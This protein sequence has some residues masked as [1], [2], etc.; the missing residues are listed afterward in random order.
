MLHRNLTDGRNHTIDLIKLVAALFVICI[1]TKTTSA[2]DHFER[3][4]FSF[5][6]DNV[7]RFAVPFFFAAS[8]FLI[9]FSNSKKVLTRLISIVVVCT[10][11]SFIFI[12][13]RSSN[14]L[15]YP[16]FSFSNNPETNSHLNTIYKILFYGYERHLWF[17][18][19]YVIAVGI[20][21]SLKRNHVTLIFLAIIFY[22]LGISGQQF[23]FIYPEHTNLLLEPTQDWLQK[24]YFTRSGMFFAFPCMAIGYITRQYIQRFR[25]IPTYIVSL[26]VVALFTLQYFECMAVMTKFNASTADYYISTLPLTISILI[27]SIKL[28]IEKPWIK[29]AGKLAGGVYVIHPLFMY[30]FFILHK[31]LFEHPA[32]PY[33]FTPMLFILSI[34]SSVIISKIP[35]LRKMIMA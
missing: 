5:I 12:Y 4:S 31:D 29:N 19:A 14:N 16:A 2:I 28:H 7:A 34:I 15:E 17:F 30:Y 24:T 11:W 3:G 22:I 33:I 26:A 32:W 10:V 8:G 23:K 21:L 1:H 35:L 18:P 25:Q 6:V 27:L 13:I 20:I 9:N